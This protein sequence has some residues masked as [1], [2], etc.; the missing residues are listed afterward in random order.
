MRIPHIATIGLTLCLLG[1]GSAI[2]APATHEAV[3]SV[4]TADKLATPGTP[5]AHTAP[6]ASDE[7]TYATRERHDANTP[8]TPGAF[9]GGET[10][11]YIASGGGLLLLVILLVLLL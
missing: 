10:Q 6:V 1:A 5:T 3:S 8:T 9:R 11:I 4:A 2:A 7:A